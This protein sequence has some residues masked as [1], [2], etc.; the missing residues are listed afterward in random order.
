[1]CFCQ[2][3]GK[4]IPVKGSTAHPN[5]HRK[6]GVCHYE[7]LRTAG[8]LMNG[9]K[10]HCIEDVTHS[11]AIFQT[12]VHSYTYTNIRQPVIYNALTCSVARVA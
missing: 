2:T 8:R 10:L 9:G 1:M 4:G 6:C 11:C 12:H 5:I 7:S 3:G